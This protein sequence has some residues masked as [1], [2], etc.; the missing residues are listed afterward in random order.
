MR[1]LFEAGASFE[2]PHPDALTAAGD[3]GSFAP[4]DVRPAL[5]WDAVTGAWS[6]A[7]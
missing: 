6:G 4:A 3:T 1:A 7:G 2:R 5:E